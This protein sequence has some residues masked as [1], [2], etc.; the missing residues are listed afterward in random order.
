MNPHQQS[1][2]EERLEEAGREVRQ[3]FQRFRQETGSLIGW[4]QQQ[5]LLR[6][7]YVYVDYWANVFGFEHLLGDDQQREALTDPALFRAGVDRPDL[8][9]PSARQYL[10]WFLI[11]PFLFPFR[12]FRRL[13]RQFRLKFRHEAGQR[14]RERLREFRL[15]LRPRSLGRVDVYGGGQPLAHNVVDPFQVGGF[16]SFFYAT[17]KL[18]LAGLTALLVIAGVMPLAGQLGWTSF[19]MQYWLLLVFPG[20]ALVLWLVYRDP[21]TA[22]LGAAP[23]ILGRYL[24]HDLNPATAG[25]VGPFLLSLGAVFLFYMFIEWF[26]MPRPLPPVLML[27]QKE[28]AASPYKRKEDSPYWLEG[29]TYWVWRYLVLSPA[30]INKPWERD[31]ERIELW[32]RADGENAGQLEWV[33]T[34][35]HYRE[36]WTPYEK[37]GPEW[38]LQQE[39][40]QQHTARQKGEAGVWLLEVDAD[41]VM[42]G[43][44]FRNVTYVSEEGTQEGGLPAQSLG[45]LLSALFT[46]PPSDDPDQYQHALDLIQMEQSTKVLGDVPEHAVGLTRRY[47]LRRPWRWWR[48]PRGAATERSQKFYAP[49]RPEQLPPASDPDLQIKAPDSDNEPDNA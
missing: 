11:G 1:S 6:G 48:Y 41:P 36:I 47:L 18:P 16:S 40:R 43:P 34:D 22:L 42:H 38:R 49:Y 29:D 27:Y 10:L 31:W 12:V 46:H 32:I 20:L 24:W 35:A 7:P 37:L 3:W 17:Y 19:L 28:G 2:M 44:F 39:A 15:Q 4:F 26:F 25:G 5:D 14:V 33:V 8:E 45:H 9:L 30:E 23:V 13:G 21:W